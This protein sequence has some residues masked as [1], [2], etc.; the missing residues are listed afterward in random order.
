MSKSLSPR[1]LNICIVINSLIYFLIAYYFV[2]FSFNLFS[3]IL[4][5]SLGFDVE[6]FYYGFTH[7]GKEWTRVDII[8]VFYDFLV[9]WDFTIII[10]YRH[11]YF[12]PFTWH[13]ET[14]PKGVCPMLDE[15]DSIQTKPILDC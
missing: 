13:I 9:L 6:L 10:G 4:T 7:S 1:K 12:N 15:H 3:M 2:V 14:I 8:L 11:R 5:K